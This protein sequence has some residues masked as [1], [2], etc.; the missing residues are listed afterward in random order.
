[1]GLVSLTF[2]IRATRGADAVRSHLNNIHHA[3]LGIDEEGRDRSPHSEHCTHDLRKTWRA[4][5]TQLRWIIEAFLQYQRM[6]SVP[7]E[8][9]KRAPNNILSS[10]LGRRCGVP[11]AG[12][13]SYQVLPEWSLRRAWER[14]LKM[15]QIMRI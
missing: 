9:G 3:L 13:L 10:L 14:E 11:R 2:R 8:S 1:M 12:Y 6:I 7:L 5:R 4:G 15:S